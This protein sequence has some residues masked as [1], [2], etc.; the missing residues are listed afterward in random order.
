MN[1]G[2][3][4]FAHDGT[5]DY[6]SQAVLA[7][8]LV[9][10]HLGV[11][12]SLITDKYTIKNLN[13]K[14]KTLPFDQIIE[15]DR[16]KSKNKRALTDYSAI[17]DDI[18]LNHFKEKI[19]MHKLPEEQL[20]YFVELQ[21]SL[22]VKPLKETVDF[23]ND[24][25]VLAYELTPYDRTLVIDSDFLIFSDKLNQC[26]DYNYDFLISPGMLDIQENS[27]LPTGYQIN[28]YS[29]DMLWATTFMFSKTEETKIFFNLLKYI[30][31]EY[32]YFAH[33]Y[34]FEPGQ[35]RND[36]AFSIACHILGAHGVD[37]WHGDLPI[38][39]MFT[40][41]DRIV[42]VKSD[43]ITFLLKDAAQPSDYLLLKTQGQDI[44]VMNKRDILANINQLM[45][46]T[47]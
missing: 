4:I 23:I 40:D 9:I 45:E 1:K 17:A 11:P 30:Q 6:G 19:E 36:F 10:K 34:D 37:R 43:S 15:I 13:K 7:A 20:E 22:I 29:I 21:K 33:L 16:P 5:L 39:L 44:H 3:V 24:S 25:R 28:P 14:F 41:A 42:D 47:V 46:L 32:T 35:Y 27:I 38:P 2:C 8:K 18:A 26:W 12:V 31:K